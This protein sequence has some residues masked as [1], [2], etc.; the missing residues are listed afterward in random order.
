MRA[1]GFWYRPPGL[2]AALLAPLGHAYAAGARRRQAGTVPQSA[3]IPVICVG[4]LVA[5][6]AGKTPLAQAVMRH[7]RARGLAAHYLSRGYGGRLTG[8]LQVDPARHSAADV[9]DEPL[10]LSASAPAWIS[11]DRLAGARAARAGG[12]E[13]VVMD[14][15]FQNP[16]LAKDLSLLVVDGGAGFG[17]G[18]V[19]PAGP[20]RE[21]LADGLARAQGLVLVGADRTGATAQVA[22]LAP[23]LPVLTARLVPDAAVAATLAGRPVLAF[24]GIGRPQK[25]F[26]TCRELG[27]SVIETVSFADHHPYTGD[28]IAHLLARAEAQG[29]VPLTTE[30]DWV[31]L[32]AALQSAVFTLPVT[33]AFDEIGAL[34]RVVGA[35][36]R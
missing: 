9:G 11:A 24:A 31:R 14:D 32:P 7:L 4:N 22:A 16:R 36:R 29:A 13:A 12:A 6:G 26:D 2:A 34:D 30:K 27:L 23:G 5:G 20:L 15:G 1:P 25:F 35:M 18:R 33:L 28:E 8:P 17:N 19:I 10:L 3:G 21:D